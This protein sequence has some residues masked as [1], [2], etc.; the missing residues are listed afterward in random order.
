[1]RQ[2]AEKQALVKY[3]CFKLRAIIPSGDKDKGKGMN[4][5]HI[6][7]PSLAQ[8]AAFLLVAGSQ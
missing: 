1:M 4:I 6:A 5:V 7:K 8:A 2:F 3:F